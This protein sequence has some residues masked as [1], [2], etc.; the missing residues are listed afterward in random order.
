MRNIPEL[1]KNILIYVSYLLPVEKYKLSYQKLSDCLDRVCRRH[2]SIGT[3]R[4]EMSLLKKSG[5][6]TNRLRYRKPVPILS[7]NGK[8]AISTTLAYKKYGPWD[9]KWRVVIFSVPEKEKS[10]RL[11]F[12]NEIEQLGF[13]KFGRNVYIS[14][15]AF[16]TSAKRI[17]AKYA[18]DPYCTFIEAVKIENQ[19]YAVEKIWH[20]DEINLRYKEFISCAKA[21]LKKSHQMYWPFIAKQL[22][23]E[24]ALLY[25]DD[26]HLPDELLPKYWQ[27][28]DAY[29]TFKQIVKSY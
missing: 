26:P 13:K 23:A 15:H 28:T 24:F 5:L 4:K 16:L 12:Q 7:L 1:D 17:A 2:Y 29:H 18:L 27:G 11:S 10:Y 8:L 14:P 9:G 25:S 3:L 20:L 21:D 6:I 19:S 22:E